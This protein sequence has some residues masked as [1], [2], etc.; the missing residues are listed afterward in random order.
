MLP[1]GALYYRRGDFPSL[2]CSRPRMMDPVNPYNNLRMSGLGPAM[3]GANY[4]PG[5][6]QWGWIVSNI[7]TL[8]LTVPLNSL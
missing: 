4:G 1:D 2:N 5:D 7:D 8:D 3:A 6:G